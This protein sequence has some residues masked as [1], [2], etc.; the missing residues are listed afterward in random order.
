MESSRESKI[1]WDSSVKEIIRK[2]RNSSEGVSFFLFHANSGRANV[3]GMQTMHL[4]Y[5]K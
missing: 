5:K 2:V 3:K 4:Q 1:K